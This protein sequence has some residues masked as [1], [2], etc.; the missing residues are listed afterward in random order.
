MFAALVVFLLHRLPGGLRA[1]GHRPAVRLHRHR[2]RACSRRRCSR[3]CRCASSGIMQN[4]TLLAIPFF[5]FMGHDPRA[6]AA[7]PRTC[8][9]PSARCSARSAA[10]W[11]SR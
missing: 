8:S 7:W 3:R 6:L 1:G 4:D 11:R 10:A 2:A 5:T 9:T